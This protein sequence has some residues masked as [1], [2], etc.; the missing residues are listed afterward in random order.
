MTRSVLILGLGQIGLGFDFDAAP[1]TVV[2]T[3]ARAFYEHPEFVLAGGVDTDSR[4]CER[5]SAHYAVPAFPDIDSALT[6]LKPDVVVVATPTDSHRE[7]IE[8]LLS[9]R[10]LQAILCEKPLAYK[11]ED[12]E[13]IVAM[14]LAH[15]CDLYVNYMRNSEPGAL[16]VNQRLLDGR[17]KSPVKG[18]VWYS[19]GLLNNG[20]HFLN[21]LQNWLGEVLDVR[22][23]S[24]GRCW[25]GTDTEPDFHVSFSR[26]DVTFLA[27][28]EENFSHYT[29]ELVAV[30]GRLRYDQAGARIL[31]QGNVSDPVFAGYTILDSSEKVIK[32]D[33]ERS[34]WH[35]ADQ[36]AASL[37]G[38]RA[39]ICSGEGA[40]Q[41]IR[42]L[43]R[44][45]KNI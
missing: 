27:A 9:R 20:S 15:S 43:N 7:T 16:E 36:L 10:Q 30:N 38:R 29:V 28:R 12:A 42:T 37:N 3:H 25:E 26:G 17:I 19:K 32:T 24:L 39:H 13:A 34:L 11:L 45:I 18:V 14:C 31:W 5:F 1:G 33:Y 23:D 35:V 4:K 21:L 2:L 8:A 6:A 40:L 44:I 41:T 22:V